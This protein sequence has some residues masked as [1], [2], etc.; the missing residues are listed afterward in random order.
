[1][2]IVWQ[3]FQN[4]TKKLKQD[5]AHLSQLVKERTAKIQE[6]KE[7]I[8]AQ[9]QKLKRLNQVQ[10]EFFTNITHEFRT[11]LTL[12]IG[13]LQQLLKGKFPKK[14]KA[15]FNMMLKNGQYL[16]TLIN[17]LLDLSKLESGQMQLERSQGDLF[18]FTKDL[19]QRFEPLAN[20]K[21]QSLNFYSSKGHLATHFDKDKWSKIVYNLVANAIKFT[22]IGG[23]IQVDMLKETNADK[24]EKVRLLVQDTG[25]GIGQEN[26]TKIFNQFYQID[27]SSKRM[28]EGT[29]IGLTLVKELI[30][31]QGGQI[32]VHS[33]EKY[34]TSFEVEIPIFSQLPIE[35]ISTNEIQV[36][37]TMIAQTPPQSVEFI[38]NLPLE[39][40]IIEDNTGMQYYIKNCL[41]SFNYRIRVANDGDEGIKEALNNAPD[42]I[43]SDIMMPK[44]DGYEVVS[45]IRQDIA[46]SHIPIILLTAKSSLE[47]RLEGLER[48]ADAYLTKPFSPEGLILRV[49]KLIELR[50][51]IQTHYQK[52]AT[53]LF[54][55]A[56][57]ML[58]KEDEFMQKLQSIIL[59][60]L[61][62][63]ALSSE[64]LAQNFLMSRTNFYKKVKALTNH[65]VGKF[66]NI[67]RLQEAE[68]LIKTGN[69]N[70]S[71]V[72]YQVGFSSPSQFSKVCKRIYGKAPSEYFQL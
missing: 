13:P 2:A 43:I 44:K 6:D 29:G 50:Q 7:V 57:P 33:K 52:N 17:Q 8:E 22:N 39:I 26:M 72:A 45:S 31:L 1:M 24:S 54:T 60:N 63:E 69:N 28:Q 19:V 51:L 4:R 16:Q 59:E 70:L 20:E 48:G 40:L 66:I 49:R 58:K 27:G 3:Y 47:S 41:E 23:Y 9:A 21:N 53:A 46:T 18:A 62:N 12:V 38:D 35:E 61:V 34:G 71:S 36:P 10:K 25:V 65:T 56:T 5:K 11:P 15:Q 64:W 37:N 32:F 55:E 30:E 42:L 68:K 14:V 67:I